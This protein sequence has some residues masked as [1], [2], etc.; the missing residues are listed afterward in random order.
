MI[1]LSFFCLIESFQMKGRG[2]SR[3]AGSD[4]GYAYR[5]AIQAAVQ[6]ALSLKSEHSGT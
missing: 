1:F 2:E 6:D 4:W 3:D 5:P